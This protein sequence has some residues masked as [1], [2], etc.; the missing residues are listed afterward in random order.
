LLSGSITQG[1][2]LAAKIDVI[3]FQYGLTGSDKNKL[4]NEIATFADSD[5]LTGSQKQKLAEESAKC[6]LLQKQ[7]ARCVL[8]QKQR[9]VEGVLGIFNTNKRMSV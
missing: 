6:V 9:V 7:S 8:L 1:K 4:V 5:R 2:P 3:A